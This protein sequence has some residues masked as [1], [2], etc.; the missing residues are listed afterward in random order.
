M[1]QAG[2]VIVAALTTIMR[3]HLN[4]A[5]YIFFINILGGGGVSVLGSSLASQ[6]TN[7]IRNASRMT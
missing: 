1:D 5:R 7:T 6:H 2:S 4:L 3:S